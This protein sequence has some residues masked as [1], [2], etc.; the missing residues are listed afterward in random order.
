ME[1]SLSSPPAAQ[2]WQRKEGYYSN[3]RFTDVIVKITNLTIS[4]AKLLTQIDR[5]DWE[6]RKWEKLF[7]FCGAM[8]K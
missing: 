7:C 1:K 5:A 3:C 2:K 8:K 6:R 4:L